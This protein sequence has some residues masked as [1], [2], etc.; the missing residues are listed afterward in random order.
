MLLATLS[1]KFGHCLTSEP[2]PLFQ[3]SA[4]QVLV[5]FMIS[6]SSSTWNSSAMCSPNLHKI[7]LLSSRPRQSAA[8][9]PSP[10]EWWSSTSDGR[11]IKEIA[12]CSSPTF[13]CWQVYRTTDPKPFSLLL[14]SQHTDHPLA[15]SILFPQYVWNWPPLSHSPSHYLH[16]PF[17]ELLLFPVCSP[18]SH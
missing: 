10:L 3:S 16:T 4:G 8:P 12:S 13:Q 1:L 11:K 18:C 17:K 6:S 5:Q 15:L 7:S 2:W 9:C 14:Q